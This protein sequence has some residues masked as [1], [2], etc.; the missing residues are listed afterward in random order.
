MPW[1]R[2]AEVT[3]RRISLV[4]GSQLHEEKGSTVGKRLVYAEGEVGA[5][6]TVQH[7]SSPECV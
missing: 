2:Y 7:D 1:L 5:E 3:R 4:T 6:G